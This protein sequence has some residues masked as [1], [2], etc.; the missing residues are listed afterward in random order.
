MVA[1]QHPWPSM[2]LSA[3][4]CCAAVEPRPLRILGHDC[5]NSKNRPEARR[6]INLRLAA[7]FQVKSAS[8]AYL[9]CAGSYQIKSISFVSRT[10]LLAG[11]V[12]LGAIPW[13]AGAHHWRCGGRWRR[14]GAGADAHGR[15]Q[16][17]VLPGAG[18]RAPAGRKTTARA[19][20]WHFPRFVLQRARRA[21]RSTSTC[22]H[23]SN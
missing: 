12:W 22:N 6:T 7:K 10:Q 8:S 9:A 23:T 19:C 18:H 15:R 13:F 20:P 4:A 17:P 5:S 2:G 21:M 1:K 14:A 11:C 3:A 16:K